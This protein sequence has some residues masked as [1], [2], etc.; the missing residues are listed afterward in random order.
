MEKRILD[1]RVEFILQEILDIEK[2]EFQDVIIH[3]MKRKSHST[4]MKGMK[5]VRVNARTTNG[6]SGSEQQRKPSCELGMSKRSSISVGRPWIGDKPNLRG[7]SPEGE[8]VEQHQ[9]WVEY[10]SNGSSYM[11][12]A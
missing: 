12:L 10:K 9:T 5:H 11:M 7:L 2:R 4:K 3:F 1:G 8:V 6:F